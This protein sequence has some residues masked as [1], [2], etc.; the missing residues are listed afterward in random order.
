MRRVLPVESEDR[1]Q[2]ETV[3]E[4]WK[5][6]CARRRVVAARAR[7]VVRS[8]TAGQVQPPTGDEGRE[9]TG[10]VAEGF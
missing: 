10:R 1:M 8:N 6:G 3:T 5:R 2:P 9:L 4:V 7:D